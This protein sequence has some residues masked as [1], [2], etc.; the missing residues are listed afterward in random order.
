M[1]INK[2]IRYIK[3]FPFRVCVNYHLRFKHKHVRWKCFINATTKSFI[4]ALGIILQC[5][6]KCP[7]LETPK[8]NPFNKSLVVIYH[9][10][11]STFVMNVCS[12]TQRFKH[13]HIITKSYI[14]ASTPKYH[15]SIRITM[16]HHQ[17]DIGL[18]QFTHWHNTLNNVHTLFIGH[19][20]QFI[21]LHIITQQ[22]SN[23]SFNRLNSL[24]MIYNFA[25][26]KNHF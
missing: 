19:C 6:S 3:N 10:T 21:R 26:R 15:N 24:M 13:L 12:N 16:Y 23:I 5:C 17:L 18:S 20:S 7:G 4:Q 11:H 22:F 1:V 8:S 9:Y 2:H 14:T 25:N